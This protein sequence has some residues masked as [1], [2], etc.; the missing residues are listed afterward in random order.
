MFIRFFCQK[1]HWWQS[2]FTNVEMNRD[3]YR[4]MNS[5][6]ARVAK[7]SPSSWSGVL[8]GPRQVSLSKLLMH[9][10]LNITEAMQYRILSWFQLDIGINCD[11]LYIF[12]DFP[13]FNFTGNN[14]TNLIKV[15]PKPTFVC[16]GTFNLDYGDNLPRPSI[17]QKRKNLLPWKIIRK[18]LK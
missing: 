4:S 6:T 12:K 9:L 16:D 2:A 5:Q 14:V 8:F 10:K 11:K 13:D 1:K 15:K 18:V 3:E 17:L 7:R